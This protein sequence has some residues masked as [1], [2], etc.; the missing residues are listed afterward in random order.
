MEQ[1][2]TPELSVTH[3]PNPVATFIRF[4]QIVE[5]VTMSVSLALVFGTL[6]YV[7][8]HLLT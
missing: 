2:K 8:F 4:W 6:G 5:K 3:T 1:T 7:S